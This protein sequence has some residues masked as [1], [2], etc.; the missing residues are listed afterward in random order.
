VVEMVVN[1]RPTEVMATIIQ[2]VAEAGQ[3][4]LLVLVFK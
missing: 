2:A 1:N 4:M 3:Q